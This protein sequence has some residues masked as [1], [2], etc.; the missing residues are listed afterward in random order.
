[1]GGYDN[2]TSRTFTQKR[3]NGGL[4]NA[5]KSGKLYTEYLNDPIAQYTMTFT[6]YK[7]KQK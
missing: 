7:C 2:K 1:M 6:Q 3:R 4:Q 5:R